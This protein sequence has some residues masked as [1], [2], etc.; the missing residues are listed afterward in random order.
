[1]AHRKK[2][3]KQQPAKQKP[4]QSAPAT[5]PADKHGLPSAYWNACEL[6]CTN[7]LAE[8]RAAYIQLSRNLTN[9]SD[10][11]LRT[12]VENDLAV[13]DAVEGGL[14]P[15]R[16]RWRMIVESRPDCLAAR[17]N[18]GLVHA[19]LTWSQAPNEL[20]PTPEQPQ[21]NGAAADHAEFGEAGADVGSSSVPE[22]RSA[23]ENDQTVPFERPEVSGPR[24]AL[25][26][27]LFNWPSTGGGNMHTAGLVEFMARDGYEVRHYFARY[28]AWGIGAKGGG[29]RAEGGGSTSEESGSG[30]S[31]GDM[32]P[33]SQAIEFAES[34]WNVRAIRQRFRGR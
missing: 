31:T 20:G 18:F 5:C 30:T 21:T 17:L 19:E 23:T 9:R 34:E 32:L 13:L 1:M 33:H 29:R 25:L 28:P 3:R 16:D 4:S 10:P 27:F 14:E 15:S 11:R 2:S 7:Q 6:A 12:L 24:V 22:A 8:A 26:S